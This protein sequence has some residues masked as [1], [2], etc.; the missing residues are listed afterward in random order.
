[1]FQAVNNASYQAGAH[2]LRVGVDFLFNGDTITFPRA[3]RGSYAFSSMP[4]FLAGAYNNSGFTQTFGESAVSQANPNV[5]L[6]VQDE[7]KLGSSLTL[8]LGVR[9]DLQRLETVNTDTNNV[10]PRVGFAWVPF[11]SRRTVVRGSAG[12]FYDRV[13][14]RAV[15][16]ALL[17]AGNT[18]DLDN[19]RQ[20]SVSLSPAQ[21]GAP[22]FPNVL[23]EAVPSVTP[24]NL[25]TMD[26]SLKNAHSQ[27]GSLEVEQQLGERTTV[28][29]AYQYVRGLHLIIQLNQN[30]PACVAAGTNNGCRPNAS[31]ANNNQYSAGADSNYH[32]LHLSFL[33]RPVRWGSYRVS[34]TLSKSM[35]NVGES[36]FSSPIDPYDVWKDWARSDD[37]QRHR[38]AVSGSVQTSTDPPSGLWETLSRD[39]QLSG[40]LRA[41]SSLPF[42]ITSG[43]NTIQGTQARPVVDGELIQRNAGV[44]DDFLTLNLRLSRTFRIGARVRL[45]AMIEGYNVANRRNDLARNTVFGTGAY[46]ANPLPTFGTVTAVGDPRS[47]QFALRVRY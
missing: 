12:I 10:S 31:Y 19:L 20:I 33:Q 28:G 42:N 22:V 27:Q 24:V 26:R 17:S 2:A 39:F 13:P 30:V 1:M 15:A 6:F 44:G 43:V 35:N 38:L 4:N 34:Y 36:F 7:W 3:V 8:N 47:F 45:E 40:L 29:A 11:D 14:L 41:Y 46:P 23:G 25:T 16:N 18:T 9:Y 32:G 37:D 5:G 21:A